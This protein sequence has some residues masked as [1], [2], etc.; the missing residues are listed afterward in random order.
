MSPNTFG[1]QL[2][3]YGDCLDGVK[4]STLSFFNILEVDIAMQPSLC[5]DNPL[6]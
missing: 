2:N 5:R 3:S 4:K 1:G 6:L